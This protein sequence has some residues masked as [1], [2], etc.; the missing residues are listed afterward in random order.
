MSHL[1]ETCKHKFSSSSALSKHKKTAKYCIEIVPKKILVVEEDDSTPIKQQFPLLQCKF[2]VYSTKV[3]ASLERHELKC[4]LRPVVDEDDANN[5]IIEQQ[6]DKIR[7]LEE[8]N[9]KLKKQLEEI[10]NGYNRKIEKMENDHKI[11]MAVQLGKIEVYE[12]IQFKKQVRPRVCTELS[13]TQIP[14]TR[15]TIDDNINLYDFEMFKKGPQGL[16][17]FIYKISNNGES[18]R[19]TD[20]ARRTF[21]RVDDKEMVSDKNGKFIEQVFAS[22]K[23]NIFEKFEGYYNS[24]SKDKKLYL[25]NE[26]QDAAQALLNTVQEMINNIESPSSQKRLDSFRNKIA[27]ALIKMSG[28]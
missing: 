6:Q 5:Q 27:D 18:Y 8:E 20:K 16:A 10:K 1:C 13:A 2:C 12:K 4:K 25:E 26:D 15:K 3:K 21:E 22:I 11:A 19:C 9:S 24:I 23:D 14:F 17:E 7:D 28:R